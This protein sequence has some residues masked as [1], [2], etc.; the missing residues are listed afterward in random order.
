MI[1]KK[2]CKQ[3]TKIIAETIVIPKAFRVSCN[4]KGIKPE[5]GYYSYTHRCQQGEET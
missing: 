2:Y 4:F 5:I 3:C 1:E